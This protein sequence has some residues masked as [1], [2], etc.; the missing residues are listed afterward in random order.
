MGQ[1]SEDFD[2]LRQLVQS[3]LSNQQLTSAVFYADKLACF[4]RVPGDVLL[5]AQ[6]CHQLPWQGSQ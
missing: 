1:Q 4:S 6:V 3:C 5:L 2:R